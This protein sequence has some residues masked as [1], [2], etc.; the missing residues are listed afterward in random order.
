MILHCADSCTWQL[1]CLCLLHTVILVE[2]KVSFIWLWTGEWRTFAHESVVSW[3]LLDSSE[4]QRAVD[5]SFFS[6]SHANLVGLLFIPCT[7]VIQWQ[8]IKV[9]SLLKWVREQEASV[10]EVEDRKLDET[11]FLFSL[12]SICSFNSYLKVSHSHYD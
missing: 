4:S 10:I 9:S 7:I 8:D 3:Q 6:L 5:M 11:F 12:I 1:C 2:G